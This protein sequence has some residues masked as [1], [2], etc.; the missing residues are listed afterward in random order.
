[1]DIFSAIAEPTRKMIVE[2]LAKKGRL[3]ATEISEQFAMSAAAVSQHL[4][5]LR[6]AKVVIV[7]KDG[8]K[9]IYELNPTSLQHIAKWAAD[10]DVLWSARFKKLD[11]VLK[12]QKHN[13]K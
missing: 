3:S 1:M 6:E 12:I 5:V 9:R 4:K 8:Q 2:L 7:E 13:G 11:A 10:M